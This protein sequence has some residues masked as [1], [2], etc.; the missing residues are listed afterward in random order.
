MFFVDAICQQYFIPIPSKISALSQ[1]ESHTSTMP[2]FMFSFTQ[3]NQNFIIGKYSTMVEI[4]I[5][6]TR[7]SMLE[8]IF[9][10]SSFEDNIEISK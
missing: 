7:C 5:E 1:S 2:G 3:S 9:D 8:G 10:F 4:R 6:N